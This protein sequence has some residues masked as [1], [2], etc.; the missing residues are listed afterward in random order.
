MGTIKGNKN[1]VYLK[2][3]QS[4]YKVIK[5]SVLTD[6][7]EMS[8]FKVVRRLKEGDYVRELSHPQLEEKS[9]L[10]R[11]KAQALEDGVVAWVT[12][13]GNTG[14]TFLVNVDAPAPKVVKKDETEEA[15]KTEVK[16]EVQQEAPAVQEQ[17]KEEDHDVKM[18]E[19]A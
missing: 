16:E 11:M 15:V 14:T 13:K 1:S 19:T 4:F 10:W 12:I 6:T 3:Q 9:K 2:F 8:N 5:E 18:E 7:L 17:V